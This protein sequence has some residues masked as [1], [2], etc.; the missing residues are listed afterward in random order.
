MRLL[1]LALVV[2][3]ALASSVTWSLK[4][5]STGAPNFVGYLQIV[6]DPISHQTIYYGS[7]P[8][9]TGIYSTDLYWYNGASNAWTH[10]SGTGSLTDLCPADTATQPGDRHPYGQQAVDTVR[11][12]FWISGGANQG[13][14]GGAVNVSGAAVVNGSL[15]DFVSNWVGKT[16]TVGGV[17]CG[18]VSAVAD[19]QHLTLSSGGCAQG[20]TT[21]FLNAPGD[22]H[23]RRDLY[24]MALNSSPLSNTWVQ[25]LPTHYPPSLSGAM[26]HDPV[27]DVLVYYGYDGGPDTG[28]TWVYCRTTENPT[29]GT[30]TSAQSAAGCSV[31]GAD[32][33][34]QVSVAYVGTGRPGS[35]YPGMVYAASVQRMIIFGG[36]DSGGNTPL[37]TTWSY[38]VDTKTWTQKALSTSPPPV[39]TSG[40]PLTS[41]VYNSA[42]SKILYHYKDTPADYEYDPSADTWTTISSSGSGYT[43]TYPSVMAYDLTNNALIGMD[44]SGSSVRMWVG[45]L[46]GATVTIPLNLQET[47]FPGDLTGKT[48]SAAG[49]IARTDEPFCMGV[50]VADSVALP[51]AG[52]ST[53]ALPGASAGQFRVLAKW[54]SGNAK[55]IEACGILPSLSAGA[56]S[57]AVSLTNGG[58]GNFGGADLATDNG[59]TITV[60]TGAATITVKKAN[61]N[62]LDIV[63]VGA[64]H[65]V[66][67]GTS[68]GFVIV[69]PTSP[70]TTCAGGCAV[71][72]KSANDSSSTCAI[73][74]NGPVQSVLKCTWDYKDGSGNKY[75]GGTARMYFYKGKTFAKITA[76]L[77]NANYGTSGSFGSAFKSLQAYELRTGVNISG[78]TNYKIGC[79]TTTTGCAST[80]I[81]GTI[82]GT[83]TAYIYA[84]ALN[85][86]GDGRKGCGVPCTL[87]TPDQFY[88]ISRTGSGTITGAAAEVPPGWTDIANGSG[89]GVEIGVYQFAALG[90]KSLEFNS[91]GTI[92]TIGILSGK[93]SVPVQ[94]AWPQYKTDDLWL[95]F[96]ATA[97]A[98]PQNDFLKFQHSL[99]GRADRTQY[100]TS[101][102]FPYTLVDPTEEDAYYT[103]VV[104]AASPSTSTANGCCI[105]DVGT[106]DTYNWPLQVEYFY[107]WNVGGATNQLEWRY[108]YLTNFITRGMT[109]RF[110]QAAHFYRALSDAGLPRADVGYPSGTT[111]FSWR[112]VPGYSAGSPILDSSGRPGTTN[113]SPAN[114]N[115]AFRLWPNQEHYHT[116]SLQYYYLMTGDETTHDA[117]L[118]MKDWFLQPDSIQGNGHL[119][120]PRSIGLD[121]TGAARFS[122]FLSS[123]SDADAAA[124]IAHG[125]ST[126]TAQVQPQLCASGYPSGCS[127]GPIDG[128]PWTSQGLSR[129]RGMVMTASGYDSSD[130]WCGVAH[131]YRI[132]APF[133]A[134]ILSQGLLD[135]RAVKGS[136]WAYFTES[137]DFSYGISQW[138]LTEGYAYDGSTSHT[139]N[140]F[141]YY[142]GLDVVNSCETT[143]Y[144]PRINATVWWPFLVQNQVL[145]KV[146][147]VARTDTLSWEPLLKLAMQKDMYDGGLGYQGFIDFGGYQL[148]AVIHA[149]G[150]QGTTVLQDV[151]LTN[152]VDNGGGSY[153]LSWTVPAGAQVY[154]IKWGTKQIVEWIGFDPSIN[155]F[156][157]NPATTMNWFAATEATGIPS[158]GTAGTTQTFTFSTGQTGLISTNF[159]VKAM[160]PSGGSTGVGGTLFGGKVLTGGRVIK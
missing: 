133:Q 55:W 141:R 58:S 53:L 45:Q 135:L 18:T 84:G 115:S 10:L 101:G 16:V 72:Y 124:V 97:P 31:N 157:G 100:N 19:T 33:W 26:A 110:L 129:T 47:L 153:S 87:Y 105:V 67:T 113:V 103:A 158:P 142:I 7:V 69:G 20:S 150:H 140:G 134:S 12:W 40:I 99:V 59:S 88:A 82:S 14:N 23:P 148:G 29:P 61:F 119:I 147:Q 9:S 11:N 17:S 104:T 154:R 90:P 155:A 73:E 78:T 132:D 146:K 96:H 107:D 94:A 125:V 131:T 71:E 123:T 49:G 139:G 136:G 138:A 70:A 21:L 98:N 2:N 37:N 50:P 86:L 32:D 83:D 41:P 81:T 79:D 137:Q 130:N 159:S 106:L 112:D 57:T 151:T 60:A 66:L 144:P 89:V 28:D 120:N 160:A 1:L 95:N 116:W 44:T 121:L 145:G 42:T 8:S 36:G 63:N 68:P 54:P 80:P 30:L 156:T 43:G 76:S 91:G 24:Y 51:G 122:E 74:K 5:V 127:N 75:L 108:S 64:N 149:L 126:Y 85:Y 77:R 4:S 102:V 152:F 35:L 117:V 128:G 109:G 52:V 65:V 111:P 93:N 15:N 38:N 62:G 56:V 48:Y 46:D 118:S 39:T 13:C 6:P 143:Y 25:L 34:S 22:S 114:Y 27:N 3:L 92:A